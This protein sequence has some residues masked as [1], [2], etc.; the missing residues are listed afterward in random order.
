MLWHYYYL[1]VEGGFGGQ[2]VQNGSNSL[3]VDDGNREISRAAGT[4]E[5]VARNR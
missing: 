5:G 4:A 1:L 2:G 3:T